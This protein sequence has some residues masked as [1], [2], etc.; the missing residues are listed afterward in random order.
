MTARDEILD[1]IRTAGAGVQPPLVDRDYEHEGTLAPGSTDVIDLFADQVDEYRAYVHRG[2][3][4]PAMVRAA[5]A[6][7]SS[8]IVPP[9]L[10]STWVADASVDD[11]S[12][13]AR[14]L[15]RIDAVVT[16]AT[17]ACARTGTIVLDGSPDQGRRILSLVP[18]R[19]VCVVRTDQVVET[20]PEMMARLEP[21]RPLTFISGPSATSDIELERIEGV[22]GPRNLHVVLAPPAH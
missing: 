13:G 22:H 12:F 1:R 6:N 20:V 4:V 5:L 2:D 16:A 9:G 3:D 8:V 7:A 11:G 17:V 15:D 18:D 19:H 21:T 14:D 10:D